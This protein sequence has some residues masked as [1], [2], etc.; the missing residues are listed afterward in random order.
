MHFIAFVLLNDEPKHVVQYLRDRTSCWMS[1]NT[2]SQGHN[3]PHF[4]TCPSCAAGIHS[5]EYIIHHRCPTHRYLRAL[6]AAMSTVNV[7]NWANSE[8]FHIISVDN[9]PQG[10]GEGNQ[11]RTVAPIDRVHR[12]LLEE[13]PLVSGFTCWEFHWYPD[14]FSK[15]KLNLLFAKFDTV[16]RRI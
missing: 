6:S 14:L 9:P 1:T 2:G 13:A 16:C 4:A 8:L 15:K 3:M 11:T 7:K 10:Y 5:N 12:Q